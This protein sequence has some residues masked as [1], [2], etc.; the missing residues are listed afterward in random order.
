MCHIKGGWLLIPWLQSPTIASNTTLPGM[1]SRADTFSLSLDS[2]SAPTIPQV[3]PR[4]DDDGYASGRYMSPMSSNPFQGNFGGSVG[5][6]TEAPDLSIPFPVM[7]DI[8]ISTP[9]RPISDMNV[10]TPT[11]MGLPAFGMANGDAGT[12]LFTIEAGRAIKRAHPL[13]PEAD[14]EA[15]RFL[16]VGMKNTRLVTELTSTQTTSVPEQIFRLY[17]HMLRISENLQRVDQR[18][19]TAAHDWKIGKILDVSSCH[20][21][22]STLTDL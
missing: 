6:G 16:K 1:S 20:C 15:E 7:G 18:L 10:Q 9:T 8:N 22:D 14:A 13:G 11:H 2:P 3:R 19:E 4:E 5:T 21:L 17:L 12:R